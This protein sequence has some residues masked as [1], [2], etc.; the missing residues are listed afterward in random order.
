M[1]LREID[2]EWAWLRKKSMTLDEEIHKLEIEV[3]QAG[4]EKLS[5][6]RPSLAIP[7]S[8]LERVVTLLSWLQP[9]RTKQGKVLYKEEQDAKA[10]ERCPQLGLAG[11]VQS[12][13]RGATT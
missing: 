9:H 12:R 13:T 4:C 3:T 11:K 1:K 5:M 6:M 7:T 2:D 10:C 8:A